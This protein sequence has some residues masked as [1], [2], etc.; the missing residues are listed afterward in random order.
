VT[1]TPRQVGRARSVP[2]KRP[3]ISAHDEILEAA[4]GLFSEQGYAATS[5]R[6][7]A[8]AVGIKQASLY[9][10]FANKEDILAGLLEG[11]VQPSL[12]FANRLARSGQP[13][14][15]Q[16]YALTRFDVALLLSGR[17]NVGALY[18]LPEVR[19]DRFE[20]F[21]RERGRLRDAYG[22]RI[23]AGIREQVFRHVESPKVI[24][25]L[26]F[27]L[28][29][30]VISM[31]DDYPIPDPLRL[32]NTVAAA[33]LRLL[34]CAEDDLAEAVSQ[35]ARLLDLAQDGEIRAADK[36]G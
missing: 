7:I 12:S 9:Y 22:R 21:R 1:T 33:C 29:E 27:A 19:A 24:T 17:W 25:K 15:V 23:A 11:T 13:P 20:E 6:R 26:V 35:S 10:H 30:S 16:L 2:R 28:A 36:A 5:T 8:L 32:S 18:Q 4:A 14:H 34:S 31:R 3:G